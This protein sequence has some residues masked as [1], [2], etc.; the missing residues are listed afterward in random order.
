MSQVPLEQRLSVAP[1]IKI[2]EDILGHILDFLPIQSALRVF[3]TNRRLQRGEDFLPALKKITAKG[4][5]EVVL[6]SKKNPKTTDVFM[7]YLAVLN[8]LLNNESL[9]RATIMVEI[10]GLWTI[11]DAIMA[12]LK[13]SVGVN[14]D[15]VQLTCRFIRTLIEYNDSAPYRLFNN[16]DSGKLILKFAQHVGSIE[17]LEEKDNLEKELTQTVQKSIEGRGEIRA[18]MQRTLG[19]RRVTPAVRAQH[20]RID[21]VPR[22]GVPPRLNALLGI[23]E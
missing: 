8:S 19:K 15:I 2:S 10:S 3:S 4:I 13:G 20:R 5:E 11:R 9:S 14:S 21:Y 6:C 12:P 22:D 17:D 1:F 23:L 18:V 7:R 16:E